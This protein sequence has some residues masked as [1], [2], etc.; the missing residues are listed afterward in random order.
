MDESWV[1]VEV[2]RALDVKNDDRVVELVELEVLK[3]PN[4]VFKLGVATE[5]LDR[6][7]VV[8]RD[9]TRESVV[10][11]AKSKLFEWSSVDDTVMD[12]ELLL[13]DEAGENNQSAEVDGSSVLE[14]LVLEVLD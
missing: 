3:P 5:E 7:T 8:D 1:S 9:V 13:V 11:G 14:V 2:R 12:A 10:D 4:Q 6:L